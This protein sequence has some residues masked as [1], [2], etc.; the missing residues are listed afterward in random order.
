MGW[1]HEEHAEKRFRRLCRRKPGAQDAR[2]LICRGVAAE[3]ITRVALAEGAHLIVMSS[4]GRTGCQAQILIQRFA[5]DPQ[6]ARRL[7]LADAFAQSC[8]QLH[9]LL[10]R[11]RLLAP[12][13]LE[14]RIM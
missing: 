2:R 6:V 12:S 8:L 5:A 13:Q 7:R 1:L 11:Q 10:C 4:H 3:E 14:K 9:D